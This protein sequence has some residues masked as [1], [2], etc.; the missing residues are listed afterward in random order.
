ML[1]WIEKRA[2]SVLLRQET[3]SIKD[4][5]PVDMPAN[6]FSYHLNNL[7]QRG[8]VQKIERGMY[9]LSPAGLQVAGMVS[10]A[11]GEQR[12]NMKTVII[13]FGR[14]NDG[15]VALFEWT[16][17]PYMHML[18]L[19]HDRMEYDATLYEAIATACVD[20]LGKVVTVQF[21]TNAV[22]TIT[23]QDQIVSRMH[24]LVY[25][26]DPNDVSFPYR[27]RNGVLSLVRPSESV[28]LMHGVAEFITQLDIQTD[29]SPLEATFTY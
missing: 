8:Y 1:S 27:A 23:H 4:M 5:R 28:G 19:P 29:G 10:T 22:I 14:A 3:A 15:R 24:G 20:K 6:Q 12:P 18:T 25:E 7:I 9:A 17:Q 11:T 26:F 2:F 13:L 21:K 16:R